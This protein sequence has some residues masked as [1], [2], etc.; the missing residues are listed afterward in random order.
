[1]TTKVVYAFNQSVL[2]LFE[3]CNDFLPLS[4]KALKVGVGMYIAISPETDLPIIEFAHFLG[5]VGQDAFDEAVK[6]RDKA[7]MT[8][9]AREKLPPAYTIP[10]IP[11]EI[12]VVSIIENA[13]AISENPD[14]KDV[15]E[16]LWDI[17]E[18]LSNL[19]KMWRE[20]VQAI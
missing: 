9:C 18:L 20:G 19:T 13:L 2:Q 6:K 12:D 11:M 3:V 4:L 16:S 15:V 1:M 17:V 5:D 8:K 14:A 7:I 10:G